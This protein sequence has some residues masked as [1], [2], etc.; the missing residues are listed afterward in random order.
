MSTLKEVSDYR[1]ENI[2]S[3]PSTVEWLKWCDERY[4]CD[5]D[6]DD[7]EEEEITADNLI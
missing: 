3:N 5:D 2:F 6:D 7:E 1:M 4:Y